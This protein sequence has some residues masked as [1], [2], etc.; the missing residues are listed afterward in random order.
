MLESKHIIL[1]PET[2]QMPDAFTDVVNELPRDL[3][4]R[5]VPWSGSV[6]Q[7]VATVEGILD[8]E[9][10]RKVILVGA[11][12]GA[13]VALKIARSQPR[14][15]ERL[16][17]DS[18]LISF[19]QKQLQGMSTALKMVPGFMFRKKNKKDLL[20]QVAD[21]AEQPAEDFSDIQVPTLTI[22]GSTAKAEKIQEL[23]TQL[24]NAEHATING[25]QWLTYT[26][27]G[28][29]TGAVIAQFLAK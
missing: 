18:P 9:E 26:T 16:V 28:R 2:Q 12:T 21:V 20:K 10:I 23:Q 29:E 27:H 22:S 3:K 6:D 14:R 19:D 13:A 7:G 4:P 15:V 1:I 5:I 11:G 25:A 8:R 24:P 17:L